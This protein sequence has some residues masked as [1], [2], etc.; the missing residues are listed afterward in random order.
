MA[1]LYTVQTSKYFSGDH[2]P[3]EQLDGEEEGWPHLR[4]VGLYDPFCDDQRLGVQ[5]INFDPEK[6]IL[7]VGGHGGQ[8]I[9]LEVNNEERQI[10]IPV[11]C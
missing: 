3:N 10:E 4:K 9:M 6:K 7:A 5:K 11:R 1:P 8:I 2:E